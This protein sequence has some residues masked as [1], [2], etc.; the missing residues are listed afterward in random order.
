MVHNKIFRS[1]VQLKFFFLQRVTKEMEECL[2]RLNRKCVVG[3]V[4]GSDLSKISEQMLINGV[5]G[6]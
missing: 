2:Q 1:F 3:L 6:E 4:G 5:E